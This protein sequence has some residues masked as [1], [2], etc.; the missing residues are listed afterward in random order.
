MVSVPFIGLGG[1][2][3]QGKATTV[4]L[5][6]CRG[7]TRNTLFRS[8]GGALTLKRRAPN[9]FRARLDV[10]RFTLFDDRALIS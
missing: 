2:R 1:E 8:S 9:C 6:F 3:V 7:T 5:R 10:G 4:E